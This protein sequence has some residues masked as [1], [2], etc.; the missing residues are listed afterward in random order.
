M[1]LKILRWVFFLPAGLFVF[2][3]ISF[4]SDF[5]Q[6]LFFP[7]A[8]ESVQAFEDMR[9]HY[10]K[11]LFY[12]ASV[13]GLSTYLFVQT[14]AAVVPSFKKIVLICL[15]AIGIFWGLYIIF[16]TSLYQFNKGESIDMYLKGL[17]QGGSLIVG[18]FMAYFF[19]EE[20]V[21]F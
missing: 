5:L 15:S 9:G 2:I 20:D 6:S 4:T 17:F 7:E 12:Y 16:E 11:G 14:G 19:F 8:I 21:N 10:F 18:A 1:L 13:N 3:L